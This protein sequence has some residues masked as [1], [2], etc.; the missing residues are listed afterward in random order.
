LV[1]GVTLFFASNLVL[2]TLAI[3]AGMHVG[4]LYF[5]WV[6]IFSLM[7]V[8]QFWAFANDL[9]TQSREAALSHD[10]RRGQP[11]RLDRRRPRRGADREQDPLEP[12]PHGRRRARHLRRHGPL[13]NRITVKGERDSKPRTNRSDAKAAGR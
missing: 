11:G 4:I 12:A 9:Y 3:G 1:T 7:V 8:A 13:I 10:R 5:I 6:G 2:F